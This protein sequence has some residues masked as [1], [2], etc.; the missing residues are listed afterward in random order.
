MYLVQKVDLFWKERKLKQFSTQN[1]SIIC[2]PL[3]ATQWVKYE[4]NFEQNMGKVS[5]AEIGLGFFV[6]RKKGRI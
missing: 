2:F 3:K 4:E 6:F 1:P 5:A